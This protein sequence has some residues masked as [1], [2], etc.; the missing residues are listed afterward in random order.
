MTERKGEFFKRRA[1]VVKQNGLNGFES[2]QQ[3]RVAAV[4]AVNLVAQRI[5]KVEKLSTAAGELLIFPFAVDV[6][7]IESDTVRRRIQDVIKVKLSLHRP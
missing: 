5:A 4:E 7:I 6:A 3:K 1:E 2:Y